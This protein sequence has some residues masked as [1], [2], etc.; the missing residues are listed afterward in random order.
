MRYLATLFWTFILGQVVGYLGSSLAGATYD[1]Q[2]TSI[3]SLVAGV[4]IILL[5]LIAP[6]PKKTSH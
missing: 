1:F 3:I 4:L 5:G 2:L 6:S